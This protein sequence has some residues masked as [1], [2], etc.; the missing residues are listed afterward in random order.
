[1][2]KA[3]FF[4]WQADTPGK[5][6]RNFLKDV[7][8][9]ACTDIA[10]DTELDE[11]VRDVAVDS[12]T[13]G[14]AG[15]PPIAE[16]I[17]K[18]IDGAAVFIA[19][20][21]FTGSRIDGR[22]TPNPN[23]LIEYGWALRAIR[24]ERVI[25]VMNTAYG[26][27]SFDTLP[28]DLAHLRWPITYNLPEDATASQK[29][30]EKKKLLNTL[31][32]AIRLSLGTLPVSAE[33]IPAI[34]PA[35]E[36]KDGPARFREPGE[37][38]GFEDESFRDTDREVFLKPGSAM[39]LRL[40]PSTDIGRT[41]AV[42]ELKAAAHGSSLLMPILHGAGYSPLRSSDGAGMFQ[43]DGDQS[44]NGNRRET[45]SVAFAFKTGEVW[46]IDTYLLNY[47]SNWIYQSDLEKAF[48]EALERY[49][50]FLTKLG[51]E[52]PYH[53]KA[54]AVGL[55]GRNLGF[56]PPPDKSWMFPEKG[57]ICATDLIEAEGTIEFEQRASTA[58][59]PFFKQ[60][61]EECDKE[62]PDYMPQ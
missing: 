39:W 19:D 10:A 36:A 14:V 56:P 62:R 34:F 44:I 60:I 22:P 13:Q 47:K 25:C 4:S 8:E 16:T 32:Q 5:T 38:L 49:S 52:F 28:F 31:T 30:E 17:F 18:K 55:K 35:M 24:S 46:S 51:I 1:M 23:V 9:Q 43:A 54:G 59:L 37:S 2:S 11:A 3:V 12:D 45:G 33:Q 42:R 61:F 40:M 26:A 6:G 29:T 20:V 57:P 7:L 41:W 27:P 58:L 48:C 15:Q 21:T 53:W 50:E